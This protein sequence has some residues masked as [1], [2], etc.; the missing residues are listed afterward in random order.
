[1]TKRWRIAGI[2]FSH[3]HMGD[4]LRNVVDHPDAEIVGVCDENPEA[5][6]AA[7]SALEIPES[8]VFADFAECME[9]TKPDLAILC[10][11]TGEHALWAERI[12]PFGAH[13]FVEKPFAASL[14]DADRMIAAVQNVDWDDTKERMERLEDM[15]DQTKLFRKFT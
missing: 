6:R 3:M 11:P 2:N 14:E 13:L 9:S 10:P 8:H 15:F 12:A 5:M 7:I 1:M 4:L